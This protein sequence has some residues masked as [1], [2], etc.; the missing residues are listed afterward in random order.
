MKKLKLALFICIISL[1]SSCDGAETYQ[2]KWKALNSKGEKYEITFSS[3]EIII[4]DSLGK[5]TKNSYIQTGCGHYGYSDKSIDT[6]KILLNNIQS[7]QI[8]FPK[9]DENIGLIYIV[10]DE[11]ESLMYTI[12]RKSY[13]TYEDINKLN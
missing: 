6:Y 2:G 7:Y 9:K 4:K 5:S 1:I 13:L 8:H 10:L 3:E 12:S 11:G